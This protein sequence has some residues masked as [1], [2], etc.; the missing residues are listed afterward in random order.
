MACVTELTNPSSD[1]TVKLKFE[2]WHRE[3]TEFEQ[4]F[5]ITN[6]LDQQLLQLLRALLH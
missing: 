6:E 1:Q 5:R 2:Q 4:R 3:I